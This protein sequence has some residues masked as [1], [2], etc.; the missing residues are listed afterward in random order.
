MYNIDYT[1]LTGDPLTLVGENWIP[2]MNYWNVLQY[3]IQ[4][5]SYFLIMTCIHTLYDMSNSGQAF[6]GHFL[7]TLPKIEP[8]ARLTRHA[9]SSYRTWRRHKGGSHIPWWTSWS[10]PCD[11]LFGCRPPLPGWFGQQAADLKTSQKH[12]PSGNSQVT[13]PW[14]LLEARCIT[15]HTPSAYNWSTHS[16]YPPDSCGICPFKEI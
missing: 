1:I 5:M 10:T 9:T 8:D 15:S 14:T 6:P 12:I 11:P 13:Y 4:Y 3:M 2:V 16:G 7:A